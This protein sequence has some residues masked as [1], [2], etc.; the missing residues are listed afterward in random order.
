[1]A[2]E[3]QS[4][5]PCVDVS[6]YELSL[7]GQR[8]KLERQPMDLL[9]LFVHRRGGLVTREEIIAKLWGKDVFVDVDGSINSA[10]RKIRSALKD[11][12]DHPTYLETVVGK[13]YRFIGDVDVIGAPAGQERTSRNSLRLLLVS[14]TVLI[15]VAAATWGWSQWRQRRGLRAQI[16][17]IAVLPFENLSGD[18]NQDY[19]A[20]GITDFLTTDLAKV[21]HLRIVSRTS[22]NRYK[23]GSKAVPEIARELGVDA[24]LEGS[25]E[26][27]GDRVRVTAQLI[28]GRADRHLWANNYERAASDIFALESELGHTVAREVA[29]RLSPEEEAS[30]ASGHTVNPDAW[31]SYVKG[32]F[33]FSKR[34]RA[35]FQQS[36][37]Y[38]EQAVAQDPGFAQAYAGLAECTW[39]A[40]NFGLIPMQDALVKSKAAANRAIE[41][42]ANSSEAHVALGYVSLVGD[43]DWAGAQKELSRALELNPNNARAHGVYSLYHWAMGN[44][45]EALIEA[46]KNAELDPLNPSPL[47]SLGWYYLWTG[48]DDLAEREFRETLN[49]NPNT[50]LAHRGL[51]E[52]YAHR[53]LDDQAAMEQFAGLSRSSSDPPEVAKEYLSTYKQHGYAAAEQFHLKYRLEQAQETARSKQP[54]ACDFANAYVNLADKKNALSWIDKAINEHCRPMMGMKSEPR[55]DF[56]RA[57]PQFHAF[58]QRMGV[59]QLK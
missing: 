25:F 39:Q 12:P 8:V 36:C 34:T 23:K 6:R 20:D 19:V 38:F 46:R 48:Q 2:S 24:I 44:K 45:T 53:K 14:A 50:I 59:E 31:D 18:A 1:M 11:D 54:A 55:F 17:S 4:G 5:K 58:L 30:F 37:Q 33:Y 42:D 35:G 9:I 29:F 7:N 3:A 26:R 15:L 10:V 22:A 52:I 16:H 28:D 27:A 49:L 57:E 51:G 41:L 56:L 47:T 40:G 43:W 32:E 21:H 13:G